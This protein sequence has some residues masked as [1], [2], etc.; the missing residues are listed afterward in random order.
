M[1]FL[2]DEDMKRKT[3]KSHDSQTKHLFQPSGEV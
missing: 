3:G 1:E 2:V